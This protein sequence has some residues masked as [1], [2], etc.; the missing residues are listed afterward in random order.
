M[1]SQQNQAAKFL[2]VFGLGAVVFFLTK[3]RNRK[4]LSAGIDRIL[5]PQPKER[6]KIPEPTYQESD[7]V[8]NKKAS[9]AMDALKAYIRAYNA[10]E[11]QSALDKMN[12]EL[13]NDMG[14][15]VYRRRKD[16]KLVV[17]DTSGKDILVHNV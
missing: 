7:L 17:K 14:V 11:P 9:A 4:A 12:E 8:M 2:L 10:G 16:N 6:K 13:K 15:E 3:P 1:E 5:E